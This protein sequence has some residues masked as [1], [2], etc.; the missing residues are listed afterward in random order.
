MRSSKPIPNG[1]YPSSESL[2]DSKTKIFV[3][4]LDRISRKPVFNRKLFWSPIVL[5]ISP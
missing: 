1:T 3:S 5:K 4:G 2:D